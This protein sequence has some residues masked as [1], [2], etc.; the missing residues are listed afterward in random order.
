MGYGV[1]CQECPL[2][3][4]LAHAGNTGN[5]TVDMDGETIGG[6]GGSALWC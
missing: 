6:M 4:V 3:E 1:G 2:L 5:W